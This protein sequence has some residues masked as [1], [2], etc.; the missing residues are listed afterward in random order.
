MFSMPKSWT[1]NEIIYKK[2][3]TCLGLPGEEENEQSA[4]GK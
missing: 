3:F 2:N 1:H 4:T